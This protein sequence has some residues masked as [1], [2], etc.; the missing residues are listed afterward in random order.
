MEQ[1]HSTFDQRACRV[2]TAAFFAIA[3]GIALMGWRVY[4]KDVA[5]I[6]KEKHQEL[7]AIGCLK[8]KQI[9][10]WRLERERDARQLAQD[11]FSRKA[12]EDF[13]R[14]PKDAKR[15]AD[16]R[17]HLKFAMGSSEAVDVLLLAP[18]GALLVAA[19]DD[20][21]PN[22]AALQRAIAAALASKEAVISDLY[23]GREGEIYLDAVETMYD[24]EGR[25]LA[26]AVF[27]NDAAA[28]LFPLIQTWPVPSPS[29]ETLLVQRE[30]EKVV[31]LNEL[32]HR[33][34]TA[35]SL[36]EPLAGLDIPAVQAVLGKVGVFEGN[37]YRGV[38]VLSNL[39]PIPH[40]PWFIVAKVDAREIFAEARTR[41]QDINLMFGA[42]ILLAAVTIAYSCRRHQTCFYLKAAEA[43]SLRLAHLYSA[44][45]QSNQSITR[46]DNVEDLLQTICRVVVELGGMKMA[47]IG[48]VDEAAGELHVVS[49][50][51]SG[52]GYLEGIQ[53]SLK[54]D[55]PLGRGPTGTAIRENRPVWCQDFQ[56]DPST[57]PWHGRGAQYGWA[58]AASLPIHREGKPV[59]AL[60]I[61][62]AEAGF[63][64]EEIR[65]LLV[66]MACDV[67]FALDSFAHKA[68]SKL[69]E[70]KINA[71]LDEKEE[72]LQE[73]HHRVKNNMYAI[74]NLLIIQASTIPESAG[75]EQL[76]EA[77]NR[78][79]SMML[80]YDK[81]LRSSDYLSVA[82]GSFFS[83][84][85]DAVVASFSG[86]VS[87]SIEKEIEDCLLSAA[88]SEPLG[89]IL[90]EL[91]T[92]SMKYAFVGRASGK[93]GVTFHV[94]EGRG[95][96]T[97]QDDGP[98]LPDSID[99]GNSP[100]LGL[101]LIHL[102]TKQIGGTVCAE[103]GNGAK[104][105]VE[106]AV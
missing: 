52:I 96:L 102:L 89:L 39:C 35:L 98:G 57:V 104:V 27:R 23:R 83:S 3:I 79:Q 97:V 6:A 58:A 93:I 49:S 13:L 42:L 106:F 34:K 15:R 67:S 30:G 56:N 87:V 81:L 65:V 76:L 2:A 54:A 1:E 37:D 29:A 21:Q 73:V 75:Q 94:S 66:E 44:L 63:F 20:P 19:M 84:L 92:N 32:R 14:D 46:S 60:T 50:F 26:V 51:G 69:A 68:E 9:A 72:L 105:I 11:L 82:A 10:Q 71:L 40:S 99:F 48:I 7:A 90:N 64:D 36:S 61:Y 91:L 8:A 45:S 38:P 80:L 33:P 78:V 53:I 47:W 18:D 103:R 100:S 86:N 25:P 85:A 55:D 17:T 22:H 41:A 70:E 12:V 5:D 28:Y 43:R 88:K 4:R 31:Y 59:G 95:E 77:A 24:T 101:K 62:S 16:L 74:K